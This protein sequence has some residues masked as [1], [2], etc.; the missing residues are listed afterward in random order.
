M[1]L[2]G[3]AITVVQSSDNAPVL[4]KVPVEIYS[5]LFGSSRN[6]LFEGFFYLS[7]GAAFGVNWRK[8]CKARLQFVL[9]TLIAGLVGCILISS[10][11]HLPFCIFA[12]VGLSLVSIRR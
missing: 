3:Y 6:G 4:L 12:S 10:D 7:L 5:S 2:V 8:V 1:L 11:A 9:A